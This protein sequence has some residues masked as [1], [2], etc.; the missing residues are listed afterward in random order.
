MHI[1]CLPWLDLRCPHHP[2][3]VN[4]LIEAG[5]AG[6]AQIGLDE[7]AIRID[8]VLLDEA[9]YAWPADLAT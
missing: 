1:R 4:R 7:H 2:S 6:H 5:A 9:A 8:A 3:E